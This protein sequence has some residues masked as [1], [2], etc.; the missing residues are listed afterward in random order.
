MYLGIRCFP[1][2]FHKRAA[3]PLGAQFYPRSHFA[4]VSCANLIKN[5]LSSDGLS[6][7]AYVWLSTDGPLSEEWS[8]RDTDLAR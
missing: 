7:S 4:S 2:R 5:W 8:I 1:A 6:D 3:L